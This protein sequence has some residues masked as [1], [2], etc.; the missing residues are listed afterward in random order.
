MAKILSLLSGLA[1]GACSIVG[2]RAGTEEPHYEVT[3]H[4]GEVEI[5][6]YASRLAAETSVSADEMSARSA[7]F[8]RLANFIFGG[9]RSQETIEMTAPV[10][11]SVAGS[12][13]IAMTAPVE[14]DRDAA[15][16]SVI[17]FYMPAKFTRATLPEP[18]DPAVRIVEVPA[19][20]VAVLR[21]TGS[22]APDA[23]AE[24]KA[25]LI[26]A[27]IGSEWMPQGDPFAWFYDPPW[28]LPFLRRNETGVVVTKS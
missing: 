17:R 15:S 1:L 16:G 18:T 7:G 26:Q 20:T 11:Q 23:V 4:V 12:E 10:G 2:V 6:S 13:T 27:L 22:T 8:R 28:T 3:A 21:F 24:E 14:Q 9:N 19:Q 5:R 25:K